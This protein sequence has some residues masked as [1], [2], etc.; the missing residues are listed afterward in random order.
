MHHD[1]LT[2][3]Y[4]YNALASSAYRVEGRTVSLADIRAPIFLVATQRDHISPWRSVYKL[5]HL[6]DPETTFVLTSGGHNAGILSEP[7]HANRHFQMATRAAHGTWIEPEQWVAQTPRHEGSW[8]PSWHQ[9]LAQHSSRKETALAIPA[10]E[11]LYDAPGQY[12][13]QRHKD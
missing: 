8:W 3:L 13:L 4:L 5:H 6:C 1:Y 9:W 10:K 7:G 12:V 11:A 2:A